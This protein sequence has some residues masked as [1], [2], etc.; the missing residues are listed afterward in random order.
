MFLVTSR[1]YSRNILKSIAKKLKRVLREKS[2]RIK[3]SAKENTTVEG[4]YRN[5]AISSCNATTADKT[6]YLGSFMVMLQVPLSIL[7]V[8]RYRYNLH[9]HLLKDCILEYSSISQSLVKAVCQP[10]LWPF[11][12]QGFIYYSYQTS[13]RALSHLQ[14]IKLRS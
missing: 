12:T 5:E 8:P 11:S 10:L 2:R 1:K 3:A 6:H 13:K 4:K 14:M 9:A 7:H